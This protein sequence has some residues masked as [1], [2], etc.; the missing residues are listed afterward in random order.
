MQLISKFTKRFRFL[1]CFIVIFS[2]YAWVIP[3]KD[4][5]GIAITNAF[6]NILKESNRK[7]NKIWVNK[8]SEFYNRL[9]KLWLE[10]NAIEMYSTHNEGEYVVAERFIRTLKNK[11]YK[12][13]I[14]ISKNVYIGKSDEILK[15][16][17]NTYHRTIK[18][19]T[20]DV[21]PS[22]YIDFNKENNKESPKFKMLKYQNIKIFLQNAMFQTGLMKFL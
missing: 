10:K 19:K 22:M 1:S 16:Y 13:M 17:S 5:K 11:T 20:I 3:L 14:S 7:P 8:G 15:K 4:E 18:M 6:L 2:K 21:K 9:M 12:Y